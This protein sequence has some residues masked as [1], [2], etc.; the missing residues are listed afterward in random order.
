MFK[1]LENKF[2]EMHSCGNEPYVM[3]TRIE[4]TSRR[5]IITLYC[6]LYRKL[7]N[8]FHIFLSNIKKLFLYT[9]LVVRKQYPYF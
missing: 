9:L 1:K 8:T 7:L 6:Y 3:F 4:I 5:E 2:F